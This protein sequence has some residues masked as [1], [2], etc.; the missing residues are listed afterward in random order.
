MKQN[1]QIRKQRRLIPV[2]MVWFALLGLGTVRAEDGSVSFK[3][4]VAPIFLEN[5]VA[6]HDARKAEG[7]YR[8]DTFA[9]LSKPGDSGVLPLTVSKDENAELLRRLTTNDQFERMPAE[10]EALNEDQI[11][12]VAAWIEQGAKFDGDDP[13]KRLPFVIPPREYPPAP[14]SYSSPMQVTAV[15]FSTE[16]D[17]IFS[18]GYHE[19]LGW[20]FE[21]NLQ[22]RI[23]NVGQQT[24]A[25]AF[26]PNEEST[27]QRSANEQAN[28]DQT[29]AS[30]PADTV[31]GRQLVVASGR[32]GFGGDVRLIDL[33]SHQVTAV[34]ARCDDVILDLAFRPDGKRL[35]IASADKTI[36]IVDMET[37]QVQQT[38]LS[39]A[40]FVTAL[41]WSNDGTKLVS[42]SRDKT[43]KVFNA[44]TGQLLI[45]YQGHGE[46][47]RG[48]FVLPDGKQIVSTGNDK[49]LHRW[50]IS[51]AKKT[52]EV[53]IGGEGYR[54]AA[55]ENCV[56][57]PSSDKRLVKI[58]LGKNQVATEFK[59]H[60]DWVLCSAVDAGQS[61]VVTGSHDGEIR[62]WN[63]ADG[64]LLSRWLAQPPS[65]A[66]ATVGGAEAGEGKPG[67]GKPGEG[68]G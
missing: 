9:E 17:L 49:K 15:A 37:Q 63:L 46:A 27:T 34:L 57:V 29:D 20:D 60:A 6:C 23:G 32:P 56:L 3:R 21:G 1:R 25:I 51:D 47:V 59:G 61:K 12:M 31:V 50:N 48:V 18:G 42:A 36:R 58:D 62:V 44:E 10:S 28:P 24:F 68:E 8:I 35:A 54:I 41:A 38:L 7:G 14:A 2:V 22:T 53:A 30:K 52:A 19:I 26:P 16:H 64:T 65:V 39:H 43:A 4:D 33:T 13:D 67:T 40:D 11:K 66:Q 5:C 45:S 55:A